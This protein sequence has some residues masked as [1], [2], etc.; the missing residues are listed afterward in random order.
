MSLIKRFFGHLHTVNKHRFLVFKLSIKAGIPLRGLLH[1]L[2]KYSPTEFI[3]SVKF[4]TG[5]ESPIM[6]AK[7]KYGYSKAWLHHFG[8]NKHHYEYWYDLN[9][10]IKAP[11]IPYKYTVEMICDTLAAGLTYQGKNWYPSYQLEYFNNRTDKSLINE[12]IVKVLNDVYSEVAQFG[13]NKTINKKNLK[14]IY[15]KNVYK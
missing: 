3:E 5:S 10:P 4:Y 1:D 11:V 13:I 9:A 12:K 14:R 15:N 2:S 6:G 7:K 8:R